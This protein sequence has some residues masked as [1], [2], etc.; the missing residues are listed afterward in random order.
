MD[1]SLITGRGGGGY[2]TG[3][4]GHMKFY[5]YEK[6]E[7]GKSFSHA[8]GGHKTFWGIF[9]HGSLKF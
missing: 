1:W 7:G 9:L 8:A 4:R 5:P 6:G 3:G 2:R